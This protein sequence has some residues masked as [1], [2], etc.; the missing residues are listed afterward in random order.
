V[1]GLANHYYSIVAGDSHVMVAF[2]FTGASRRYGEAWGTEGPAAAH[3]MML[4]V[5]GGKDVIINANQLTISL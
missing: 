2:I 1:Q 4:N 3:C 5:K